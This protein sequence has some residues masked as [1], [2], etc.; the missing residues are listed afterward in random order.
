MSTSSKMSED[1][2]GGGRMK[3]V[4]TGRMVCGE[5]EVVG[6]LA[7]RAGDRRGRPL[8]RGERPF[9]ELVEQMLEQRGEIHRNADLLIDD[10]RHV[11]TITPNIAAEAGR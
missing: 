4:L 9:E 11:E 10:D 5:T 7:S 3:M 8:L 6:L 1:I 2:E